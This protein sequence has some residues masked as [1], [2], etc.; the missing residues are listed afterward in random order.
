MRQVPPYRMAT[1]RLVI[2]CWQPGDAAAMKA[3][4]DASLDHLRRWMPWAW[5]D[6]QPLDAK[7]ELL[8]TFRGNFDLGTDFVYSVWDAGEQEVLGGTGLHPRVGQ[9]ALEIGYWV[10]RS[11]S[12]QGIATEAA[13]VLTRVALEVCGVDRV[14]IAVEPGNHASEAI[15]VK[16]GFEREGLLRRR[17]PWRDEQPHDKIVFSLFADGSAPALAAMPLFDAWDAAGRPIDL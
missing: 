15:P 9:D 8:R 13:G 10:R 2:R 6:P 12:G 5:D 16:L 17:L 4:V 11:R 7:I 1:D 14:E 3:A